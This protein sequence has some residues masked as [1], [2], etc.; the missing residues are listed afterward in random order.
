MRTPLKN[1]GLAS[2]SD[3]QRDRCDN[4]SPLSITVLAAILRGLWSTKMLQHCLRL[5]GRTVQRRGFRRWPVVE[6][7]ATTTTAGRGRSQGIRGNAMNT[8]LKAGALGLVLCAAHLPNANAAWEPTRPVEFIIPAGPGGGADIMAR[9]DPGHRHQA[10][11]DEAADGRHQQGG[12]RRRRRLP[13]RQELEGQPAQ[14][15]HH[16]VQPVHHA[17]GDRHPVQ[18]EGSHPGRDAGAR[19]VRALGQRRK[20]LQDRRRSSST[21]PRPRTAR[22]RWAAPGRSRKTRSSPKRSRRS[23]APSS[24]TFRRRGGGA[25]AVQLVGNHVEFDREQS[26]RGDRP[27]ARRQAAAALRVRQQAAALQ[28]QDRRK[29]NPGQTCRPASRRASISSI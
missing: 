25:V 7:S 10:Q 5:M 17:D 27:L 3:R 4:S 28:G 20:A 16:A 21:P 15:R 11:P 18:L 23:P 26:E 29:A 2:R 6:F 19:R 22:S 1:P 24:S 14:D 13:R 8:M 12:R 9:T